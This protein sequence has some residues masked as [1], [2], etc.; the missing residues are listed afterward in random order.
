MFQ[1]TSEWSI[2]GFH[3]CPRWKH[4]WSFHLI[5]WYLTIWSLEKNKNGVFPSMQTYALINA[6]ND[7]VHLEDQRP[8]SKARI[9]FQPLAQYRIPT[10]NDLIARNLQHDPICV[11]C[12]TLEE[13][14]DHPS[15]KC[16]FVRRFWGDTL[17]K[18]GIRNRSSSGPGM[19]YSV[20]S[21]GKR[22]Q[23][24]TYAEFME[25][26]SPLLDGLH[27]DIRSNVSEWVTITKER[28]L[29]RIQHLQPTLV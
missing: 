24:S 4:C 14:A 28:E 18:V 6:N 2:L 26:P 21:V 13:S 11:P 8:S 23:E 20:V 12:D 5:R 7:R 17:S 19:I 3:G 27:M 15:I 9:L 16:Y 22:L 10:E 1:S 29:D 25:H